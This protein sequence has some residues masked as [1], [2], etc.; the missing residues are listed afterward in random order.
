MSQ[1]NGDEY[2]TIRENWKTP[3]KKKRR[4]QE[5]YFNSDDFFRYVAVESKIHSFLSDYIRKNGKN[6]NEII[7]LVD[8]MFDKLNNMKKIQEKRVYGKPTL[9][10]KTHFT[11]IYEK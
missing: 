5:I 3:K 2:E 8:K 9:D 10:G 11:L 4:P 1:K 7:S 6:R